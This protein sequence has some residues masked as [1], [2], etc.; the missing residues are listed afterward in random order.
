MRTR[1]PGILT[2]SVEGTALAGLERWDG[3]VGCA[4]YC[5]L[6]RFRELGRQEVTQDLGVERRGCSRRR[7]KGRGASPLASPREEPPRRG[8]R[9]V[10]PRLASSPLAP[11]RA[12]GDGDGNEAHDGGQAD[13][14]QT[15][16]ARV[17]RAALC[18]QE[19]SSGDS[20]L[21]SSFF[22]GCLSLAIDGARQS[23]PPV[24]RA[25]F[26]RPGLVA[27]P[28]EPRLLR[29]VDLWPLHP[30]CQRTAPEPRRMTMAAVGGSRHVAGCRAT[31]QD[32][33][34]DGIGGGGMRDRLS[35]VGADS[36]ET[37]T[38]LTLSALIARLGGDLGDHQEALLELL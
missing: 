5:E 4:H 23:H 32:V 1:V 3:A 21:L 33:D 22:I 24:T 2:A 10:S 30:R 20:H 36:L 27:N 17:D 11:S 16:C 12:Q 35:I 14:R 13:Q 8:H 9:A 19:H 15:I 7:P 18:Q 29:G 37:A 38:F 6:Q 31:S 34:A 28:P 26:R 25:R